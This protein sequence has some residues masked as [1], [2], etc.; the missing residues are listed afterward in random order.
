MWH[1]IMGLCGKALNEPVQGTDGSLGS[2]HAGKFKATLYRTYARSAVWAAR[3]PGAPESLVAHTIWCACSQ[4]PRSSTMPSYMCPIMETMHLQLE[5]E[6]LP[7]AYL[8][9]HW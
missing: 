5:T 7:N 2:L 8:H 4:Q 3:D 1:A 9:S 6:A